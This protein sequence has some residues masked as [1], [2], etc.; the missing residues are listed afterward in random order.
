M[1]VSQDGVKLNDLL[2]SERTYVNNYIRKLV[3]FGVQLEFTELISIPSLNVPLLG[4][5]CTPIIYII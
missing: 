1:V 2:F 3:P 5:V 4:S